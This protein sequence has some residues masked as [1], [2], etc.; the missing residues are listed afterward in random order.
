[1]GQATSGDIRIELQSE[2]DADY[3][4]TQIEQIQTIVEKS[5]GAPA[6]FN[7]QDSCVEG[8]T[9][10]C[11]VYS[12]RTPNGEF[13]VEQVIALLKLMVKEGKILPPLELQ[14]ELLVQY[15]GWYVDDVEFLNVLDEG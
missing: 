9:F 4:Y 15:H 2:E 12:N 13:Q 8:F 11:N 1:M 7:L 14:A 10:R 5:S 6:H 3:V